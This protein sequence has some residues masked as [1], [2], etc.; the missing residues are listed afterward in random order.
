M[1]A[2]KPATAALVSR[3]DFAHHAKTSRPR[4][5]RRASAFPN[6]TPKRGFINHE[7]VEK[8]R[9]YVYFLGIGDFSLA[10]SLRIEPAVQ[11]GVG[12]RNGE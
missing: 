12:A 1:M 10:I 2:H 6:R 3:P 9:G 7:K 4:S 8:P 11:D 5:V